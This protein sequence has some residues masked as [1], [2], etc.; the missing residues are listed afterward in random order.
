MINYIRTK[1][2]ELYMK[3]AQQEIELGDI[4]NCLKY[5]EKSFF[6]MPSGKEYNEFWRS[7]RN[8]TDDF[9]KKFKD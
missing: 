6:W 4:R 2:G 5:V 8:M 1:I 7:I 9:I 3:R